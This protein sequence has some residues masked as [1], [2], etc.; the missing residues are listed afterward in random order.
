VRSTH[1]QRY[2][3]EGNQERGQRDHP[4]WWRRKLLMDEEMKEVDEQGDTAAVPITTA[5]GG[6]MESVL[7][8]LTSIFLVLA[9]L[10]VMAQ[11]YS[12]Y[13]LGK[14]TSKIERMK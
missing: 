2:D 9:V 11:L 3:S 12:V 10:L 14:D 7:I 1:Y 6:E 5:S 13:G 8:V 4:D